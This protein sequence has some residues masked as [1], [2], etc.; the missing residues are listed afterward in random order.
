MEDLSWFTSSYSSA[1]GQ[2]VQCA[3]TPEGGMAVRDTKDHHGP[4]LRF[5]AARWQEFTAS[6]RT[7]GPR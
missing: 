1:N 3:R 2:C 6:L 7:A 4:V 5:T